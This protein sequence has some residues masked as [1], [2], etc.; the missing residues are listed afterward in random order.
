MSDQEKK[1]TIR[2]RNW[3][4]EE[5]VRH[6]IP[7]RMFFGATDYHPEPQWLLEAAD[8]DKNTTRTFACSGISS[9]SS[10]RAEVS[11]R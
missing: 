5:A 6:I 4:G 11:Q 1:V 7:L 10:E 9:W 8:L 3:K 2:Y